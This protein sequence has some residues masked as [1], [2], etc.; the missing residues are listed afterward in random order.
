RFTGQTAPVARHGEYIVVVLRKGQF[1]LTEVKQSFRRPDW[2]EG[3]RL[4]MAEIC[5]FARHMF[6]HDMWSVT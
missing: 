6:S 3:G 4:I 5:R 1:V 2:R